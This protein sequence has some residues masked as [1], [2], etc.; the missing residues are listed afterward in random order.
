M[1]AAAIPTMAVSVIAQPSS[2]QQRCIQA[3][4]AQYQ[5]S[6]TVPDFLLV[7]QPASA[8]GLGHVT[9]PDR[10]VVSEVHAHRIELVESSDPL[11]IGGVVLAGERELV[12]VLMSRVIR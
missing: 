8:N 6:I 1:M 2:L 9:L 3:D 11:R 4:E 7:P 12:G 5:P 10:A